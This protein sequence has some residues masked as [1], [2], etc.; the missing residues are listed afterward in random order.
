MMLPPILAAWYGGLVPGLLAT[1][2]A[3]L[4]S[5]YFF[6]PERFSWNIGLSGFIEIALYIVEGTLVTVWAVGRD[7]AQEAAR[8]ASEKAAA[9]LA[10]ISDGFVALDRD[11]HFTYVNTAAEALLQR[12]APDL[13]GRTPWEVFPALAGTHLENEF[14]RATAEGAPTAFE[15]Y[16]AGPQRWIEVRAFPGRDG[17]LSVYFRDVTERRRQADQARQ[18]ASIVESSEDGIISKDLNGTILTWN[19]GAQRMYGYP[20]EETIGKPVSMLAPP[21]HQDET[22]ALIERLRHGVA[23]ERIETV[24]QR[25]DGTVFPVSL[26]VSPIRDRAGHVLGA[27]TIARD[28]TERKRLE[29]SVLEAQK[30]ESLGVLAGGLAHDFNNLL[31]GIMGNTGLVLDSLPP[32]DPMRSPL[33]SALRA[34]ERAADLTRQMLAY[35]GKGRFV[36]ERVNL[37]A[38][39]S[40]MADLIRSSLPRSVTLEM[41]L[42]PSLPLVEADPGQIEQLTMNLAMNAG[43]AMGDAPGKVRIATGKCELGGRAACAGTPGEELPPG[44]YVWLEVRD[45]GSGMDP[46]TLARIFDPFFTTKFMGRGL[47]LAAVSGIIRGH[48]GA[49]RVNSAPGQGSTFRVLLPAAG[50]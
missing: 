16:A 22:T 24:R 19:R 25:K 10:S 39:L 30:M 12:S 11:F 48:R 37:S 35:S 36:T 33:E 49:L 1:G 34:S 43:E 6:I 13:L 9:I 44:T 4:A 38:L 14:R 29:Q 32:G 27:S 18:L 46:D 31:T 42:A 50:R 8:A 41:E 21:G 15:E 17:G 45:T 47:G 40:G 28:I 20:A 26:T 3:A 5:S 7:R 2:L 23:V